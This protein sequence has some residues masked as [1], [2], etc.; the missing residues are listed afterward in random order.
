MTVMFL[1]RM[2]TYWTE[3]EIRDHKTGKAIWNGDAG[4]ALFNDTVKDWDFSN[5]HIIYV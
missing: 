3:V 2:L 1:T 4:A 5:G